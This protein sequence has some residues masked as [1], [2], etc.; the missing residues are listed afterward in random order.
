[1]R[2]TFIEPHPTLKP[3]IESLWVFESRSG[4]PTDDR[5][6]AAPNGS[7][8]LI[9]PYENSLISIADGVASASHAGRLYFV[10]NRD[11][12]TVLRSTAQSTGF[13]AIEFSPAGAFPIFGIPMAETSDGLWET[14]LLLAKWSLRIRAA[15]E[16]QADVRRKVQIVQRELIRLLEANGAVNRVVDYCVASLR[17]NNGLVSIKALAQYTGYSRRHLDGLFRKHVGLAPKALAG[18]FRF[19][20]YYRLWAEQAPYEVIR[21]ALYEQ[22][23]D[24]SHFNREFKK[25][26]GHTPAHFNRQISN[27]F[28]RKVTLR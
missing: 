15:L 1:M 7:P 27:E 20:K 26:T 24:E 3:Y 18:I 21:E 8:K 4:F 13:I 2:I 6:V 16:D 28:G 14:D 5:S 12:S 19:Q 10:G 25:M 11:R 23:Y 17:Q 9:I 22:Y